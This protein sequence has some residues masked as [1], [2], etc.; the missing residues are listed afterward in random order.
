LEFYKKNIFPFGFFERRFQQKM[1]Q[2]LK[3]VFKS[4]LSTI[5]L[6]ENSAFFEKVFLKKTFS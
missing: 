4:Q 5:K 3:F 6:R 1:Q 2:E